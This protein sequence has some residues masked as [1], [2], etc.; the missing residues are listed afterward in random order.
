[1]EDIFGMLNCLEGDSNVSGIISALYLGMYSLCNLWRSISGP[2]CH[3][4][5]P[6]GPHDAL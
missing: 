2:M 6:Y 3:L 5:Y 1:M 4:S